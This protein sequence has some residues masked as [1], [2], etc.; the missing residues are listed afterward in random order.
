MERRAPSPVPHKKCHP[1]RS[2]RFAKRSSHVV[3]EP[4]LSEVEGTPTRPTLAA[5]YQ[6]IL[7]KVWAAQRFSAAE[8]AAR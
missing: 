3:E 1:E 8:R 6:G 2:S 7:P 5:K 4:A